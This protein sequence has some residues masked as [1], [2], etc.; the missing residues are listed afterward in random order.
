MRSPRH[1]HCVPPSYRQRLRLEGFALAICGAAGSLLLLIAAPEAHRGLLSSVAQLVVV[2]LLLAWLG[3]LS[4]HR[5]IAAAEPRFGRR[6]G[7]GEPTPVWQIPLIVLGLTLLAGVLAGWDAGLRVTVGCAL[8]GLAQ[9][10]LLAR[11]VATNEHSSRRT[12][13]RVAGSRILR[14]TRL[15]YLER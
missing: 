8:V 13:F 5:A 10:M 15:G 7:S 12:Y 2:A 14:G 1:N 9:A 3:P 6:I 11:I 4:V